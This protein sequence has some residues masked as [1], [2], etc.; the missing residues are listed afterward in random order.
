MVIFLIIRKWC[1][2]F[3]YRP[4]QNNTLKTFFQEIN[5]SLS[6][7]VNTYDNIMLIGHKTEKQ[8]LLF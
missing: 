5:L 6:T 7:I 8:Q 2:L 4:P 1:I 3:A